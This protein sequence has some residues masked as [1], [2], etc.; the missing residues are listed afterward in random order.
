MAGLLTLA[1]CAPKPSA[2]QP[3]ASATTETVVWSQNG[4]SDAER[5]EYHRLAE[6]SEL[7]PHVLLA[8]VVSVKTGRV[9]SETADPTWRRT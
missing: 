7:M 2:P 8:N 6:G 9:N 1:G 3:S 5:A 4:W